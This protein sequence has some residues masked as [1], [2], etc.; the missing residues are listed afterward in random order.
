MIQNCVVTAKNYAAS[1]QRDLKHL[2]E[3]MRRAGAKRDASFAGFI[4]NGLGRAT[5][6]SLPDGGMLFDDD[7]RGLGGNKVRL[8]FPEISIEYYVRRDQAQFHSEAFSRHV[9][10]RLV[11][12]RETSKAEIA[13]LFKPKELYAGELASVQS[14]NLIHIVALNEIDGLWVPM[15]GS[16]LIPCEGGSS[17]DWLEPGQVIVTLPDTFETIVELEGMLKAR[18]AVHNDILGEG[19]VTL[20]LCEALT[21]NNVGIDTIQQ[22]DP[23]VNAR[24]IRDGKLPLLE[25]KVLTIEV[26]GSARLRSSASGSADRASPRQ[27]LRRGH[28]RAL[29]CGTRI[30]VS[31]CVVGDAGRGAV[32][33]TYR[34]IPKTEGKAAL[35]EPGK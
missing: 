9:A 33:K 25:A 11:Y 29:T 30:W 4:L 34:P 24:R 10:K 27:H 32:S 28:I 8:P 35:N 13:G 14:D 6:F 18:E 15:T 16:W 20:E 21:C 19:R 7:L 1:A 3:S 31:A 23:R 5:H 17:C 2:V 26:P 12:A 22:C